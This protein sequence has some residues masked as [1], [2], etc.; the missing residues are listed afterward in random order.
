MVDHR[1]GPLLL[2]LLIEE[3][4]FAHEVRVAES[5]LAVILQIGLP[6]VVD[7]A[8][9]EG[10]KNA[11]NIHGFASAPLVREVPGQ[12]GGR[13]GMQPV[14]AADGANAGLI[15]AGHPGCG[16]QI[17]DGSIDR[18][19]P[20]RAIGVEVGQGALAEAAAAEEVA[21][22]LAEPL[23]GQQMVVA[24]IDDQALQAGTI[25]HRGC[26]FRREGGAVDAAAGAGYDFSLV[27]GGIQLRLRQIEDLPALDAVRGQAGQRA[28]AAP[29]VLDQVTYDAIR[30]K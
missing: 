21:H 2:L 6:E 22:D 7:S 8:T 26:D 9:P 5:M 12:Q 18:F 15:E 24:Q 25:L 14:Q 30:F 20:P 11:G 19:Q 1:R 28:T 13:D 3:D 4:Q 16:R 27:L 10:R 17:A 29:A 23:T